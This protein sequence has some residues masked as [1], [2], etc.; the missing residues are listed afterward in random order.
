MAI[1]HVDQFSLG[2]AYPSVGP[3]KNFRPNLAGP[4]GS[5]VKVAIYAGYQLGKFVWSR[6]WAKGA[7]SGA[8]I[9]TGIGIIGQDETGNN[10]NQALRAVR[11]HANRIRRHKKYGAYSRRRSNCCCKRTRCC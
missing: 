5:K 8:A 1:K 6:P 2:K 3:W 11:Q 10:N 4:G 7:L 9:G